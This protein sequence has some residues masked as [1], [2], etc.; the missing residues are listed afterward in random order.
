MSQRKKNNTG[1]ALGIVIVSC[2]CRKIFWQKQLKRER[3]YFGSQFKGAEHHATKVKMAGIRSSWSHDIHIGKQRG[4]SAWQGSAGHMIPQ[5]GSREGWVHGRA[6]LVTW[7]PHWEAEMN[8]AA[9][10]PF[11]THT[12][13]VPARGWCCPPWE[14]LLAL[15]QSRWHAPKPISQVIPDSE[16]VAINTDHL[17]KQ[18]QEK[19]VH[20]SAMVWL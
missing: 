1:S 13:Q 3:A 8:A 6:Q 14:G 7:Y 18:G 10:L 19:K 4:M 5:S 16:E 17:R 20:R 2:F 12:A 15:T 11:S 9:L